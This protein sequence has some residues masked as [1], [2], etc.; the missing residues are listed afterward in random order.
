MQPT[1]GMETQP[2][3]AKTPFVFLLRMDDHFFWTGVLL[4][5]ALPTGGNCTIT[6][7]SWYVPDNRD[8]AKMTVLDIS[9]FSAD[10]EYRT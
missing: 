9:I 6:G 7:V 1:T 5:M 2:C 8:G 3:L 4:D 10:D